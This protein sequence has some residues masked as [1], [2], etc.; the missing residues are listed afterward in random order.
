[1]QEE[2]EILFTLFYL[3]FFDRKYGYLDVR[4]NNNRTR[5]THI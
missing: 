3:Y 1:M 5:C 2:D 4:F